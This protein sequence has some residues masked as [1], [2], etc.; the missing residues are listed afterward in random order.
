[1]NARI[2][3]FGLASPQGKYVEA[4][5]H[6]DGHKK[7]ADEPRMQ[8]PTLKTQC[9]SPEYAAPEV[10]QVTNGKGK[11]KN[12][13]QSALADVWSLGVVL[14]AMLCGTLPFTAPSIPMIV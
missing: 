9:G 8:P 5:N 12:G 10:L 11:Q 7:I 3:D 4:K 6:L 1:M 13:Y 2:V 14:Y